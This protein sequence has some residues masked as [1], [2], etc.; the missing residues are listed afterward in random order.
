MSAAEVGWLAGVVLAG[1]ASRRMGSDKAWLD[2]EGEP[3][4]RRQVKVL[5]DAGAEPVLVARRRDQADLGDEDVWQVRD[6]V[7]DA[8]PM[9][10]IEAAMRAVK[11]PFLAVL[12]V[13]MPV[14]TAEWFKWLAEHCGG[15]MGVVAARAE[16]TEP[17]AA[18]YPR[19]ALA[20]VTQRLEGGERSMRALVSELVAGG[21]V[22]LVPVPPAWERQLTNWNRPADRGGP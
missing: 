1:G 18:I 2:V 5:R 10:G 9:A 11:N 22:R 21:L 8:G 12:A 7:A 6:R 3:L 13:D 17:L 19:G 16:G 14:V 15:A 4:W 20:T